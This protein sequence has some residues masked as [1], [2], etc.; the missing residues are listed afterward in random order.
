[1]SSARALNTAQEAGRARCRRGSVGSVPNKSRA[2]DVP[3][4]R[5][6]DYADPGSTRGR[7]KGVV[8]SA[9]G[10][11]V[12]VVGMYGVV[13]GVGREGRSCCEG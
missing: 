3:R 6:V 8:E 7:A 11:V 12:G 4:V 5:K 9:G 1:M 13:V 2:G 10:A